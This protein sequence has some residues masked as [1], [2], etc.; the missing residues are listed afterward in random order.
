MV[1]LRAGGAVQLQW[2]RPLPQPPPLM[3]QR[4]CILQK[5]SEWARVLRQWEASAAWHAWVTP[6]PGAGPEKL[7]EALDRALEELV[8]LAGGWQG[9]AARRRP[10]FTSS[11]LQHARE[12]AR[13]LARLRMAMKQMP[14]GVGSWQYDVMVL[15]RAAGAAGVQLQEGPREMMLAEVETALATARALVITTL[16]NQQEER[17]RRLRATVARLW[18]R[19]PGRVFSWLKDEPAVWGAVPVLDKCGLQCATREAVD[20][21]VRGFWVDGVLRQHVGVD[22]RAA[23]AAFEA[24]AFAA[25]VPSVALPAPAWD[26]ALV[27]RVLLATSD[28]VSPGARSIPVAIWK[29]LPEA[30]YGALAELYTAVERTGQWPTQVLEAYVAMIPKTAGGG[31]PQDQRPIFGA[32]WGVP[33]LGKGGGDDLVNSSTGALWTVGDGIPAGGEH[34]A[35]STTSPRL[36]GG[37]AACR[38][39]SVVRELRPCEVL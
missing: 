15:L 28:R 3:Q 6:R 14:T 35:C 36:R 26:A 22:P 31:R 7:G 37:A 8:A 11:A 2:E 9:R 23:W 18:E 39:G 20:A 32:G 12:Q 33:S 17:A 25:Y 38:P 13:T 29:T 34:C 10:A 5:S 19:Q 21:V 16:T 1:Q 24:S 30:S 4:G 27:Q